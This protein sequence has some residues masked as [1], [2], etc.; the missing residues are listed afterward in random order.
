M[1]S[2]GS[3]ETINGLWDAAALLIYLCSSA[4]RQDNYVHQ[5]KRCDF[6][7]YGIPAELLPLVPDE[8]CRFWKSK[9]H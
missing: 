1:R 9:T 2:S 8:Q 3:R 7:K 5:S 4:L 6:S